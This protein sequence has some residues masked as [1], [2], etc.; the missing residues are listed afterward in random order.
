MPQ[1]TTARPTRE[2]LLTAKNAKS[3]EI[4]IPARCPLLSALRFFPSVSSVSSVIKEFPFNLCV[5]CVLLRLNHFC[6]LSAFASFRI[7][8]ISTRQA[9][10]TNMYFAVHQVFGR[11]FCRAIMPLFAKELPGF[12]HKRMFKGAGIGVQSGGF[13]AELPPGFA[14]AGNR[15]ENFTEDFL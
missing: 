6:M 1:K 9:G 8:R 13:E 11:I 2:N 12:I 10:A 7:H 3:A 4:K 14:P 15:R 5:L